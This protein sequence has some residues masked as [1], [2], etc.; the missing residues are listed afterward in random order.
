MTTRRTA[1]LT[2]SL[3]AALVTAAPL[4]ATALPAPI[5]ATVI[6]AAAAD[7]AGVAAIE[8]LERILNGEEEITDVSQL[9]A[10]ISDQVPE[11]V[12]P[13][14]IELFGG[15]ATSG[16]LGFGPIAESAD[17][18]GTYSVM[19]TSARGLTQELLIVLDGDSKFA[20]LG[21]GQVA[22]VTSAADLAAR[23]G[24]TGVAETATTVSTV[25]PDGSCTPVIA[26]GATEPMPSGSMFKLF[27]LAALEDA[28]AAGTIDWEQPLTIT[29][30]V[31]SLPSGV[32]QDRPDGSTVTVR[33]AADKMISIS[34]NTATDLLIR[35]LG[36]PAV[37]AQLRAFGADA[38]A[39]VM[40]TRELFVIA[41]GD[42]ELRARYADAHTPEERSAV[43]ADADR[44]SLD[45]VSFEAIASTPSWTDRVEYFFTGAQLCAVHAKLQ[46]DAIGAA[47]PVRDVLSINSGWGEN[48][49]GVAYTA[50]K[51][52][53]TTGV[54]GTSWYVEL[55]DGTKQVITIQ[56]QDPAP[57]GTLETNYVALSALSFA[58]TTVA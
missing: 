8:R 26:D 58:T 29:P 37:D 47:A 56:L 16:P 35:A 50:F 38:N 44:T 13:S 5:T 40:T 31:K 36:K 27:V 19:V 10:L 48:P 25:N 12:K 3:A 14:F 46:R 55:G 53:S 18:P 32:L 42:P 22:P 30:D 4:A 7:E 33:E 21:F 17:K 54:V 51:G 9:N 34:D 1:L 39:P 24:A 6:G 15:L 49:P 28:I 45:S 2:A 11:D 57:I 20:G 52:G 23:V 43:Q 41:W